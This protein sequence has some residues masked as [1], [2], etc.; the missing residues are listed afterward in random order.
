VFYGVDPNRNYAYLWG[1]TTG[2]IANGV[3]FPLFASTSLNPFD[4]TFHGHDAF[5]EPEVVNNREYFLANNVI[6]Y[7]S[8]H[9]SGRLVLR[10][11]GHTTEPAPDDAILTDLGQQLADAMIGAGFD[12]PY[13]NKIGLGLYPTLGTS[14][15]WAYAATGTLGYVI[16]HSTE[17]HPRWNTLHAPGQ[18]WPYAVEMFMRAAEAA[19]DPAHSGVLEGTVTDAN[20]DPVAATLTLTKTFT[21]PYAGDEYQNTGATLSLEDGVT[22]T[23]TLTLETDGTFRWF[24][25]PSTR[26]IAE[27]GGDEETYTLTVTAAD[28][29]EVTT[30]LLLQR[31]ETVE[32]DL[33]VQ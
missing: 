26:P 13:E 18:V 3:D 4:Q 12:T 5:T 32:L 2:S 6:T 14:N 10:P 22:E 28:G 23:Q 19:A 25:N 8:N 7:L 30:E 9:T 21:T 27:L 1:G 29:H 16:E 20:G 11:W 33:T 31:G 17:F 15:D 24:L